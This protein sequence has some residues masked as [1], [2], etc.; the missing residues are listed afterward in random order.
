V[1]RETAELSGCGPQVEAGAGADFDCHRVEM[2][3]AQ[4]GRHQ[5]SR[6]PPAA[7]VFGLVADGLTNA[8]I[9]ERPT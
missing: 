8:A 3:A 1:Y 2:R 6:R 4:E 5:M 7:E 9:A